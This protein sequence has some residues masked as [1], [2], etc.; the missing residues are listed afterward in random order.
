MGG[1]GEAIPIREQARSEGTSLNPVGAS[2]LAK[3]FDQAPIK[4]LNRILKFVL[5]IIKE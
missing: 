4:Y 3:A 1:C 2:L 5:S